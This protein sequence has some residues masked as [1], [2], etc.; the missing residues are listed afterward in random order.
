MTLHIFSSPISSPPLSLEVF[1][2]P[3][4]GP[5]EAALH[6]FREIREAVADDALEVVDDATSLRWDGMGS[7]DFP[8]FCR[9][10]SFGRSAGFNLSFHLMLWQDHRSRQLVFFSWEL[11]LLTFEMTIISHDITISLWIIMDYGS[12]W[13]NP[14]NLQCWNINRSTC[15]SHIF[16]MIMDSSH[17]HNHKLSWDQPPQDSHIHWCPGCTPRAMGPLAWLYCTRICRMRMVPSR[18]E[19]WVSPT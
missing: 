6:G 7:Q 4:G 11:D 14:G 8:I 17:D 5:G 10:I 13:I 12:F 18:T 3:R 16:F 9:R 1:P 2:R 19:V 15:E